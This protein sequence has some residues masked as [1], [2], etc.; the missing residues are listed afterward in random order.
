MNEPYQRVHTQQDSNRSLYQNMALA[1]SVNVGIEALQEI[2]MQ[3][4]YR[5]AKRT[6]NN[7]LRNMLHNSLYIDSK[8]KDT[9]IVNPITGTNYYKKL[10]KNKLTHA[11]GEL[12]VFGMSTAKGRALRYGWAITGGLLG[13]TLLD[14]IRNS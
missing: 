14:K 4:A 5:V 6:N 9:G 2:G 8:V 3:T 10:P 7:G 11:L 12:P 13:G 1:V